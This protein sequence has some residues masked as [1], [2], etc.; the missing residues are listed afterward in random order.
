MSQFRAIVHGRVQGVCFRAETVTVARRLG[1]RG[2][3]RNLADGSVEVLAEGQDEILRELVAF[4][5]TGP[6][7]AQV[8][9]VDVDWKDRTPIGDDFRIVY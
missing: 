8:S 2:S 7:L 9:R 1:L 5:H 6:A 3:A 4:L